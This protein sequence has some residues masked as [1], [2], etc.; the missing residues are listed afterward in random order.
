MIGFGGAYWWLNSGK[1]HE[2]LSLSATHAFLKGLDVNSLKSHGEWSVAQVFVHLAQSIEYSMV[3]YPSHRSE[4]F[5]YTVGSLAFKAFSQRGEMTHGLNEVIPG[6]PS[7]Q[8]VDVHQAQ[9]RLLKA[10]SDFSNYKGD[11]QSHF[12]YGE[13]SKKEYSWAHIMH[14]ENHFQEIGFDEFPQG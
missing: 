14:I 8:N 5:K 12:A 11:L 7:L 9:V 13:L 2:N 1:G 6:A 4:T 10:L 3:G